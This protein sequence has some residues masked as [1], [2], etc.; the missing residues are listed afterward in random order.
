MI[1]FFLISVLVIA[2]YIIFYGFFLRQNQENFGAISQGVFV[3]SELIERIIT[4][5]LDFNFLKDR[6]FLSLIKY[7]QFPIKIEEKGRANP[8]E[9]Y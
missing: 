1:L 8:F 9:P 7:G 4:T 3:N 2:S 6:K 5:N